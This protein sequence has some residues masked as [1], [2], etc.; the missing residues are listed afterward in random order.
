MQTRLLTDG[1]K[2]PGPD[3]SSEIVGIADTGIDIRH[4]FFHDP[5]HEVPVCSSEDAR[6]N[7]SRCVN[8]QHRKIVSYRLVKPGLAAG[9]SLMV[10]GT[11]IAGI[12]AGGAN[13]AIAKYNGHSAAKLVFDDILAEGEIALSV[14]SE[15]HKNLF[16]HS[17]AIGARIHSNS[18]GTVL[19]AY[20]HQSRDVDQFVWD[21]HDFV[22]LFA[23]MNSG[24]SSYTVASPGTAKNAICVG[25][26]TNIFESRDNNERTEHMIAM[27]TIET[28]PPG[29]VG[30]Q[31][32]IL[33]QAQTCI[34][35]EA[36]IKGRL[37]FL[38]TSDVCTK[39]YDHSACSDC[40]WLVQEG[41]GCSALT[42]AARA[43]QE[44]ALAVITFPRKEGTLPSLMSWKSPLPTFTV[45]PA[46]AKLLSS[47][48]DR[49]KVR[50]HDA[51]S[52]THLRVTIQR[53]AP[54]LTQELWQQSRLSW[55]SSRGPTFP[56]GRF[57]PDILCPG[58]NIAS[59]GPFARP[60]SDA[61]ITFDR[62]VTQSGTSM[63]TPAC[64]GAAAIVR[65][66][67]REG[68]FRDG[69]KNSTAGIQ[70]AASLVKAMLIHSARQVRVQPDD[71]FRNTTTS[72]PPGW[73]AGFAP[74]PAQGFGLVGLDAV[75]QHTASS[76]GL[77][78]MHIVNGAKIGPTQQYRMRFTVHTNS[79][80]MLRATLAWTDPPGPNYASKALVNDLDLLLHTPDGTMLLGN[81][82]ALRGGTVRAD[83]VNNV[84]QVSVASPAPGDYTLV[85]AG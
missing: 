11:H 1:S 81:G 34:K 33:S 22:I 32:F 39:A 73:T 20:T 63:A 66:Y 85:V 13:D 45:E 69:N 67:L 10:H 71:S 15:V 70:P 5:L 17:Y 42:L 76:P 78:S 52:A 12:L 40:V 77:R 64:A 36:H 23:A 51:T 8:F 24:P 44:G 26:S 25:S 9:S 3:G 16:P 30:T 27:L 46:T 38:S 18:W 80:R 47:L 54:S 75:L 21:H 72:L 41:A 79:S 61:D 74:T 28:G 60:K 43:R 62:I 55:F 65:Q 6:S 31:F 7:L 68:W 59:S 14:P 53:A 49:Q 2:R 37:V 4:V 84:E 82:L 50:D 29:T 58:E 83:V 56:D 35:Q 48:Q 57:K 19:S